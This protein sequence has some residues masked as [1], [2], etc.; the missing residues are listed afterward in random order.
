[1]TNL[2][3]SPRWWA[4]THVLGACLALFASRHELL[5]SGRLDPNIEAKERSALGQARAW[6]HRASET[7]QNPPMRDLASHGVTVVDGLFRAEADL[8][9]G[10]TSSFASKLRKIGA[11]VSP[12]PAPAAEPPVNPPTPGLMPSTPFSGSGSNASDPPNDESSDLLH[13]LGSLRSSQ[14]SSDAGRLGRLDP[15]AHQQHLQHVRGRCAPALRLDERLG[16]SAGQL[17]V[18]VLVISRCALRD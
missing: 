15:P 3:T 18:G 4:L 17:V 13:S 9:A 8:R 10:D 1:M 7:T 14:R 2:D 5:G 16:V 11:S 12:S 6:F